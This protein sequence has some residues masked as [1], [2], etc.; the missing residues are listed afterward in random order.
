MVQEILR[1]SDES[2]NQY[3]K[4]IPNSVVQ[5]LYAP[6]LAAMG[7]QGKSVLDAAKMD[8]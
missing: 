1:D 4:G 5:G 7:D 2:G 3:E 8:H 6:E